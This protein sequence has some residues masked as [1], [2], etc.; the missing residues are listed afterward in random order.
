M[1]YESQ[2]P[3]QLPLDPF[4]GDVQHTPHEIPT[5]ERQQHKTL[6]QSLTCI[7]DP[8]N[9][10]RNYCSFSLTHHHRLEHF[11]VCMGPTFEPTGNY[12]SRKL[13]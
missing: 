5:C 6:H 9:F 7:L 11:G 3:V 8:Y 2:K 4:V 1:N 13:L 12:K 10:H